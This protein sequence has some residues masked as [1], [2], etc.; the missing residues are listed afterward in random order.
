[1]ILI[2]LDLNPPVLKY[3]P[4]V[5]THISISNLVKRISKI[6]YLLL[7]TEIIFLFKKF[8]LKIFSYYMRY[9]IYD[10][11]D[12]SLLQLAF[13]TKFIFSLY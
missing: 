5:L 11:D 6:H 9:M 4:R 8:S 13:L 2:K 1:M 10:H 7:V 12:Y 3:I